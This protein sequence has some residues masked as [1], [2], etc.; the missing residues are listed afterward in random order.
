MEKAKVIK[1][2]NVNLQ[3]T[4]TLEPDSL[5]LLK[6]GKMVEALDAA[7]S[8][9]SMI[10]ELCCSGYD[11]SMDWLFFHPSKT[12][13]QFK[14]DVDGLLVKYGAEY[15]SSET[16]WAGSGDW[17]RFIVDKLRA[18]GYVPIVPTRVIYTETC[19]VQERDTNW[20]EVVGESLFQMALDHNE[21]IRKG[22]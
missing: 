2:G 19:I 18:L 7:K 22:C 11:G 13:A 9:D 17:L 8:I 4:D 6:E 14:S 3:T 1:N 5:S 15:L 21:K 16:C 10:F 20:K 12:E